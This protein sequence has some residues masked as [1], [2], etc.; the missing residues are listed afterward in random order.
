MCRGGGS[1]TC[2]VEQHVGTATTWDN[3]G[4]ITNAEI[5]AT[6]TLTNCVVSNNHYWWVPKTGPPVGGRRRIT[7][8]GTRR[9]SVARSAII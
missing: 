1:A 4:G 7:G 9:L 8:G 3:G 5:G 6:L 2:R